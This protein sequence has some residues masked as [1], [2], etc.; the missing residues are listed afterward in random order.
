MGAATAVWLLLF[1]SGRQ[2]RDDLERTQQQ[3]REV[4]S[5]L[6]S[7]VEQLSDVL[8]RSTAELHGDFGNFTAVGTRLR[9]ALDTRL[10]GIETLLQQRQQD[11]PAGS[12]NEAPQAALVAERLT[13]LENAI[14]AA[15]HE[16]SVSV[17]HQLRGLEANLYERDQR[18][19]TD[20]GSLD[21][22]LADDAMRWESRLRSM[23]ERFIEL[24]RKTTLDGAQVSANLKLLSLRVKDLAQAV[25]H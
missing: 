22:R 17:V 13:A 14:E 1:L 6:E 7:D 8:R 9:S 23:E 16:L 10:S 18:A 19:I 2:G 12:G 3:M 11:A 21:S 20:F 5:R 25:Q 24:T 4:Q 15:M